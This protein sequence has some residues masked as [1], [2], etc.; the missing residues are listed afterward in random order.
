LD[1][2]AWL[3]IP[4]T[5]GG[6]LAQTLRNAAQRH[7]VESLGTMGATLVRFLY[8]LPFAVLW[9]AAACWFMKEGLPTLNWAFIAWVLSSCLA[10]IAATALLLRVMAER[11]FAIGVAYSKTEVI[12]IAV[13]AT[14]FLG[15][16]VSPIVAM[17]ILTGTLGV[18]LMSPADKQHPVRA[19]LTG[20]TSRTALLGLASGAGFG[21]SAVGYRGASLTLEGA[22]FLVAA[23][24]TLVSAQ[25]LQTILL[26]GW[27]AVRKPT[28]A[29]NVLR[30]WR[31]SLFAGFMGGLASG[32]W[33]TAFA[34]EP[35]A[36]VRTL[37]MIELVFSLVVSRRIFRERLTPTELTG[38]ALLAS[39]VLIVSF[40]R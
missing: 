24:C 33:F 27:L 31:A 38:F 5:I 16:T 30:A 25:V 32:C 10:Q 2:P 8:G 39:G 7:L 3:W 11:N 6:A 9:L 1:A 26:G 22:S 28:V 12:Q 35:V 13:M 37:G 14:V 18:L 20:W 40:W 4:I 19:L 15:D 36:N 23:A 21:Y 17:A 29:M 34:I